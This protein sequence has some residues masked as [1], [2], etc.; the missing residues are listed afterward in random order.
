[1]SALYQARHLRALEQSPE[2]PDGGGRC[3]ETPATTVR[4]SE[5]QAVRRG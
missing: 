3:G 5:A 2:P 4:A 1:M